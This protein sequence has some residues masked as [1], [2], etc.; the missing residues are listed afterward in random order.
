MYSAPRWYQYEHKVLMADFAGAVSH[1][2]RGVPPVH[3]EEQGESPLSLWLVDSGATTHETPFASDID[4]DT[5]MEVTMPVRTANGSRCPC[6]ATGT[7]TIS[8]R[9]ETTGDTFAW[10]LFNVL[11]DPGLS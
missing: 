8:I 9:D 11:V 3:R 10:Q 6:I 7:V 2:L 4:P 1:Q 5:Y